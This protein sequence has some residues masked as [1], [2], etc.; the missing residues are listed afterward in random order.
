MR[1]VS[2]RL[3][4]H[5]SQSCYDDVIAQGFSEDLIDGKVNRSAKQQIRTGR[6]P[7][8]FTPAFGEQEP[9]YQAFPSL[10]ATPLTDRWHWLNSQKRD[11]GMCV[12]NIPGKN[13]II[14]CLYRPMYPN[15]TAEGL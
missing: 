3:R 8:S 5:D 9:L 11:D 12:A 7:S 15:N 6:H 14:G 2:N 10:A 13:R 4:Q 1:L